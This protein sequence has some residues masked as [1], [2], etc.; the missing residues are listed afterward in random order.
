[1]K[2][3]RDGILLFTLMGRKS[4]KV[5]EDTVG[6]KKCA[7]KTIHDFYAEKSVDVREYKAT[8]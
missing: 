3:Y 2:E 5:V 6:L 4:E 7:A 1:M 8:F